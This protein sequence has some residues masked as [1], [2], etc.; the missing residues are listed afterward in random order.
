[1]VRH[2][3]FYAGKYDVHLPYQRDERLAR[4]WA[5]P[6]TPG[7]E[8]CTGGLEKENR[9]GKVSYEPLNHEAMVHLRAQKIA[10]ARTV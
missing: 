4:P 10:K 7:L 6:G 2:C 9:T 3:W 5:I 8:H 1:V